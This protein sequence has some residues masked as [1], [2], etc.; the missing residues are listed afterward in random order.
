LSGSNMTCSTADDCGTDIARRACRDSPE[1]PL[2]GNHRAMIPRPPRPASAARACESPRRRGRCP[3]HACGRGPRRATCATNEAAKF[4][5]RRRPVSTRP[6]A[7]GLMA[8]HVAS[9][10]TM[11]RSLPP[12]RAGQGVVQHERARVPSTGVHE[13][14]AQQSAQ[15]VSSACTRSARCRRARRW[16]SGARQRR[17]AKRFAS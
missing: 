11:R 14:F 6:G 17:H 10:T 9:L 12:F 16:S 2:G 1:A 3:R 15:H 4:G 7:A 13:R 8:G 5:G